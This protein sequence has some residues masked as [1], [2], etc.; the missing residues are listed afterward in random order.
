MV[1]LCHEKMA[2][3]RHP[4]RN[5]RGTK[6][7]MGERVRECLACGNGESSSFIVYIKN[8]IIIQLTPICSGPNQ[9]PR[10]RHP[11]LR[12]PRGP[13][14]YRSQRRSVENDAESHGRRTRR[15]RGSRTSIAESAFVIV[16]FAVFYL[17]FFLFQ[18]CL[19]VCRGR[20]GEKERGKGIWS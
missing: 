19:V 20:A 16:S 17:G 15:R 10:Q 9:T 6:G 11:R 12:P 4:A 18:R 1:C 8:I 7:R 5:L 2:S 3:H 14:P 13:K